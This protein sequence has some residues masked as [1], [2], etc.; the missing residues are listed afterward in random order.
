MNAPA[1]I[2]GTLHTRAQR[3]H[4]VG[5]MQ[6][7]LTFQQPRDGGF[8]DRKGSQDQG[9]VGDRFIAWYADTALHGAA[10]AGS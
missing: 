5:G 8:A 2:T 3:T 9:P 4:G 7:I 10:M 1:I 6:D